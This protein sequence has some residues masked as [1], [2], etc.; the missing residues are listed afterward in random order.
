MRKLAVKFAGTAVALVM[1]SASIS[2][3]A[4]TREEAVAMVK[5]V[6]AFYK[7]YGKARM[8]EEVQKKRGQF[9]NG[10]LYACVIDLNGIMLAHPRLSAWVGKNY[11]TVHDPDGRYF[12]REAVVQLKAKNECWVEYR[13][14]D[15]ET[16]KI[17]LK[18]TYFLRVDDFII[19]C[20]VWK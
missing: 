7:K 1:L 4:A 17:G 14:E 13:W 2:L 10:E 3:Y 15:P 16:K 6:E 11:L 12:V 19:A 18:I 8:L 5:K 20:G 9:V